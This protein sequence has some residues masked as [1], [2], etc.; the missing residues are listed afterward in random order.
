MNLSVKE[1]KLLAVARALATEPRLLLLDEPAAG[2]SIEEMY[3]FANFILALRNRGMTIL[4]IEHRMEM[5]M[6]FS[7]R[8]I[9]LNFGQK[10]A[11]DTP[12][13]IQVNGEVITAY[14][15]GPV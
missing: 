5:V 8:V 11:D 15:G 3:E 6:A 7:D 9:V 14:L 12:S 10:I 1:Q 4:L 2:L 13:K